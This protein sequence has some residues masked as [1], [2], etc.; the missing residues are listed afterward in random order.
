MTV[1]RLAKN[2][3]DYAAAHALLRAEGYPK[4]KLQFPT[5]MAFDADFKAVGVAATRIEDEMI[6]MGPLCLKSDR[7]RPRTAIRL[8]D[9]YD[10][11]MRGMGITSYIFH[12]EQGNLWEKLVN[13][14]MP[15]LTPY[16][17]RDGINYYIRRL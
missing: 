12:I 1:Y 16:A 5:V 6:V 10:I 11:A 2:P 17:M 4:Q 13:K 7:R 14:A 8:I 9:L 3:G 15:D